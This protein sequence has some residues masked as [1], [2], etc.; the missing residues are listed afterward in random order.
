MSGNLCS[1][2]F[3]IERARSSKLMKD[4]EETAGRSMVGSSLM[5][6]AGIT[7]GMHH[8]ENARHLRK[9]QE[10]G[11]VR[12]HSTSDEKPRRKMSL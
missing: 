11:N 3:V 10:A 9:F 5:Q 7:L 8:S 12:V 2:S 4:D 6:L 1:G